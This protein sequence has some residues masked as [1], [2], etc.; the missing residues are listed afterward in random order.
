MRTPCWVS[1]GGGG[2]GGGD[3]RGR[4]K[5]G[6]ERK[7]E[8]GAMLS[9]FAVSLVGEQQSCSAGSP[10]HG[11]A[12]LPPALDAKIYFL[13]RCRMSRKGYFCRRS[14][15]ARSTQHAATHPAPSTAHHAPHTTHR[16]AEVAYLMRAG[17]ALDGCAD[18]LGWSL[19]SAGPS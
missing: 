5:R 9:A 11:L 16:H 15:A 1:S 8:R 12:V 13:R 4:E 3:G 14:H 2:G 6:G 10:F 19:T 18:L 7:E 17:T